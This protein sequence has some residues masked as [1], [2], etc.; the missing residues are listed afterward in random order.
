LISFFLLLN[1]VLPEIEKIL[2]LNPSLRK[3]VNLHLYIG[4]SLLLV[5]KVLGKLQLKYKHDFVVK[6]DQ[7]GF[8]KVVY[9]HGAENFGLNRLDRN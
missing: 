2:Y 1:F 5:P 8:F 3:F 6:I 9:P 7:Q 4:V